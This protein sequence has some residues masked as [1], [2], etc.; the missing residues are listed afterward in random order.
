MHIGL[1]KVS[2][3]VMSGGRKRTVGILNGVN[4]LLIEKAILVSILRM[5]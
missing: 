4:H 3:G 2:N 1:I 5:F